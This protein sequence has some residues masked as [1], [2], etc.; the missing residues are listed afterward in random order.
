M[1]K[2]LLLSAILL[3]F[4]VNQK[5]NKTKHSENQT[6]PNQT[7]PNQTK[8]NQTEDLSKSFRRPVIL[9]R[10]AWSSG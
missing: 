5:Q 3:D 6:K 7:K 8:P 1:S 10:V 2:S 4:T 9:Q